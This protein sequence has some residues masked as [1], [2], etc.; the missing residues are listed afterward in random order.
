[1]A[2]RPSAERDTLARTGSINT[3]ISGLSRRFLQ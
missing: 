2:N 1:M 3:L